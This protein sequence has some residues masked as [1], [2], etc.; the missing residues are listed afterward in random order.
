MSP[1]NAKTMILAAIGLVAATAVVQVSAQPPPSK[2]VCIIDLTR[3]PV[4]PLPLLATACGTAPA[5]IMLQDQAYVLIDKHGAYPSDCAG[6][7][8][9]TTYNHLQ[10]TDPHTGVITDGYVA[11]DP[12]SDYLDCSQIGR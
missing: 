10:Y 7:D 12:T 1:L 6:D 8:P 4:K 2:P 9:S 3:S 11:G 5:I